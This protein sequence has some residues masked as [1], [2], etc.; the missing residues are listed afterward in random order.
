[1]FS[2]IIHMNTPTIQN[3]F[4]SKGER[5]GKEFYKSLRCSSYH[6][7]LMYGLNENIRTKI[8]SF[9]RSFLPGNLSKRELDFPMVRLQTETDSFVLRKMFKMDLDFFLFNR[10]FIMAQWKG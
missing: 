7:S 9:S 2:F 4:S 1:M 5:I 8:V 3:K 10:Q 6:S